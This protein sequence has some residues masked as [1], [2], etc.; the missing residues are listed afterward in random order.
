VQS[1]FDPMEAAF[2]SLAFEQQ[3][4]DSASVKKKRV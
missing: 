3:P 2:A 1:T 4:T